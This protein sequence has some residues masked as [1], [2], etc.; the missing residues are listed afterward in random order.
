MPPPLDDTSGG[1]NV[2]LAVLLPLCAI[3]AFLLGGLSYK[4]YRDGSLTGP[5]KATQQREQA[6]LK[7]IGI[8]SI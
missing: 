4:Y 6:R 5:S 1:G 8:S 7:A 2:A 3:G